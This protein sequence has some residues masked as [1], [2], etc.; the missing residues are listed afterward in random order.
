MRNGLSTLDRVQFS[1]SFHAQFS[2]VIKGWPE[3]G[4]VVDFEE[5]SNG[6]TLAQVKWGKDTRAHNPH[7]LIKVGRVLWGSA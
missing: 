3:T 1:D 2:S 7:N 5:I 4:T 6:Q